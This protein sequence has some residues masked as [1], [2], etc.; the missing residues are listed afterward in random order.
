[1]EENKK[2]K[3]LRS[4]LYK[5]Q[6]EM[7]SLLQQENNNIKDFDT[8][9]FIEQLFKLKNRTTPKPWYTHQELDRYY[10]RSEENKFLAEC[11]EGNYY[12]LQ[13]LLIAPTLLDIVIEVYT[14]AKASD[15]YDSADYLAKEIIQLITGEV[16]YGD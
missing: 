8:S 5:L 16:T 14:S 9:S 11:I 15:S 2:I 6:E 10:I 4:Q 1:M 12:D 7:E 13:L 3:K